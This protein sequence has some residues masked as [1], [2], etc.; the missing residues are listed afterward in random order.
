MLSMLSGFL[1]L[2]S[3]FLFGTLPQEKSVLGRQV[4]SKLGRCK[5]INLHN[6]HFIITHTEHGKIQI[7]VIVFNGNPI[8]LTRDTHAL[9]TKQTNDCIV[10][11]NELTVAELAD[12]TGLELVRG[13]SGL[14]NSYLQNY[15]FSLIFLISLTRLAIDNS[16]LSTAKL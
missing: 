2:L 4:R 3:L 11:T 1:R 6:V 13:E 15:F 8:L 7:L 14:H 5:T 10:H 16:H 9:S 12:I